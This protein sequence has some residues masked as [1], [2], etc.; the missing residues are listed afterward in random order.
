MSLGFSLCQYCFVLVG[1]S[2]QGEEKLGFSQ[3]SL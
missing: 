1:N 3:V 2:L